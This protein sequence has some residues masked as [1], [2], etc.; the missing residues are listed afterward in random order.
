[1]LGAKIKRL[2]ELKNYTQEFV[3]SEIKVSQS[4]YSRIESDSVDITINKLERIAS[5][6]G[7]K[8]IEEI[9]CPEHTTFNISHNTNASGITVNQN[10][11]DY[12]DQYIAILEEYIV[13]LKEKD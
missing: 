7:L 6:L 5:V 8:G 1:M 12:R 4:T 10:A 9:I 2:R 11:P 3:A 13:T